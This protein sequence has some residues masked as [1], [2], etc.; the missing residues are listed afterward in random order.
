[1]GGIFAF[2]IASASRAPTSDNVGICFVP[3]ILVT[4]YGPAVSLICGL[5]QLAMSKR[6]PVA[7]GEGWFPWMR[8]IKKEVMATQPGFFK[9]CGTLGL[10]LLILITLGV[11]PK[12]L[13]VVFLPFWAWE[14]FF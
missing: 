9:L 10:L 12:G 5:V 6:S 2:Y 8:E 7:N 1:M 11:G 4:I 3:L 13:L 14:Y